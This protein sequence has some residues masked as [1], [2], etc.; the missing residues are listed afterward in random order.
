MTIG[1]PDIA[2]FHV[3]TFQSL[4]EHCLQSFKKSKQKGRA[5]DKRAI[6]FLL[7]LVKINFF[8]FQTYFFTDDVDPYFDKLT[9][10]NDMLIFIAID[11]DALECFSINSIAAP[12]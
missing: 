12:Q 5:I 8:V 2:N 9:G 3:G 7:L 4:I 1:F 11:I 10:T 6:L